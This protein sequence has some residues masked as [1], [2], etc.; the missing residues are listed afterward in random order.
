MAESQDL[1]GY[2]IANQRLHVTLYAA[3]NNPEPLNMIRLSLGVVWFIDEHG[4]SRRSIKNGRK[5]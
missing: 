4:V 5:P 1:K 2:L 3:T